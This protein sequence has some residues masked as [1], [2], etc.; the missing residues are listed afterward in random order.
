MGSLQSPRGVSPEDAAYQH[1][2]DIGGVESRE[3]WNRAH[4]DISTADHGVVLRGEAQEPPQWVIM[5]VL[6][7]GGGVGVLASS[8]LTKAEMRRRFADEVKQ[9]PALGRVHL[10]TEENAVL[11]YCNGFTF[12]H[13]SSYRE[14]M[15]SLSDVWQPPEIEQG[16]GQV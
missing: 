11:F 12:I 1:Y 3:A 9:H 15:R 16:G 8:S 10:R 6:V 5:G 13:G 4:E 2:L 14:C 7:P